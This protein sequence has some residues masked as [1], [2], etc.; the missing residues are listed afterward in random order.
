MLDDH[1]PER[2]GLRGAGRQG[3]PRRRH[4]P[5]VQQVLGR[6]RSVID[7]F[8]AEDPNSHSGSSN[9]CPAGLARNCATRPP[10]TGGPGSSSPAPPGSA[11][12]ATSPPASARPGSGPASRPGLGASQWR[13]GGRL[14]PRSRLARRAQPAAAMALRG[15]AVSA[16]RWP[17]GRSLISHLHHRRLALKV[18]ARREVK[19]D[20]ACWS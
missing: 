5:R 2:D 12:S 6:R 13:C 7:T 3:D 9:R 4:P 15:A 11:S 10:P 19:G 1:Q 14:P 17:R 8:L 20:H 16:G 18:S